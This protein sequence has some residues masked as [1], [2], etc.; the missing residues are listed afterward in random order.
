MTIRKCQLKPCPFCGGEAKFVRHKHDLF[1]KQARCYWSV[2]HVCPN[3]TY[4]D[5]GNCGT[6][7]EAARKWNRRA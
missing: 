5:T 2:L 6:K 4:V 1:V 3:H 7:T